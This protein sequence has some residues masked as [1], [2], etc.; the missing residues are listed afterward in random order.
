MHFLALIGAMLLTSVEPADLSG[1]TFVG[2]LRDWKKDTPC[3]VQ[4]TVSLHEGRGRI[5]GTHKD[6][7]Y[8]QAR[9]HGWVEEDGT[10][11]FNLQYGGARSTDEY[12]GV[13]AYN[14]L[15][16]KFVAI[17]AT[18]QFVDKLTNPPPTALG[19]L[20][21]SPQPPLP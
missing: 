11:H 8:H 14:V 6:P 10:F 1:K 18:H 4:F 20:S 13:L 12:K 5:E 2:T 17:K 15:L 16:G 21:F 3:E 7:K 19:E 9:I